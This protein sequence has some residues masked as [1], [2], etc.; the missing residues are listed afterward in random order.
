MGPGAVRPCVAIVNSTFVALTS[1]NLTVALALVAT[2]SERER[3]PEPATL[4]RPA[5]GERERALLL[6]TISNGV[7]S[8]AAR[9]GQRPGEREREREI[10]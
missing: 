6:G 1:T 5:A 9:E 2:N 3:E 10:Y 7:V 4:R 8:G